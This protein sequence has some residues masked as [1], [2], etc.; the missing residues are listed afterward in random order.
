MF[1]NFLIKKS[2]YLDYP[3]PTNSSTN[4]ITSIDGHSSSL[5]SFWESEGHAPSA[6]HSNSYGTLW[7]SS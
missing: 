5:I 2:G 4:F 7:W 1:L 6:Y 3:S